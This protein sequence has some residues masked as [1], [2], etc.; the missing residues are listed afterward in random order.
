MAPNPLAALAATHPEL[1]VWFDSSP[2]ILDAWRSGVI[3]A[4]EGRPDAD[5]CRERLEG[6]EGV[7]VGCTTNPP[8]TAQA[9]EY[10]PSR[11]A[12]RLR[13]LTGGKATDPSEAMWKLYELVVREGAERF[14]TVYESS[15]KVLGYLSGQVD[16]RE[17]ESTAAM[18][19]MGIGL[20]AMSPN[21]MIKMP[22]VKEGIYGITLLTA[23]GIPTNATLVF[24]ISQIVA[25]AEAVKTGLALAR[26]AGVDLSGW[27]S[28][29][30]MML[31][32]FEDHPAFDESARSVGVELTDVLRR[33]S[34]P[35]IFNKAV[36]LYAERGYESKMLA[37]SMR[38]G[39]VV[40]GRIRI[41]HLEK[42]CAQP[43]VLTIFPN[44]IEPWLEEYDGE[45]LPTQ[46]AAVPE[47]VL[48]ALLRVPYFREGYEEG[49]DPE[50]FRDHPAVVATA[51][52]FAESTN[53][54][55]AWVKQQLA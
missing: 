7:L 41:W 10:D 34:G 33:W 40:D 20:H 35:A 13:D 53:G 5:R 12:D 16:P 49:Q 45:E 25:V 39:P 30:T 22:G 26:Q 47:E 19:S 17:L 55:E 8:L 51:E 29:C 15:G 54:L 50:T 14:R 4:H 9:V 1:E 28:V 31:G 11:W 36:A 42:I 21:V 27:R 3:A 18:V 23:L 48:D 2:L 46:P 38:V 6:V 32:R 43:V 37:A 52:S 24:T 44:I